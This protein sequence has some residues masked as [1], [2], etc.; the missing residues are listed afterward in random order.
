MIDDIKQNN[1]KIYLGGPVA[2]NTIQFIHTLGNTI[3]NSIEIKNG[4]FWEVR[5]FSC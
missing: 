2:Q 5:I 1:F 4:L 3:K